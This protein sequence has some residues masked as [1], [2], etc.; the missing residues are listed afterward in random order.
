M[1]IQIAR[2][3]G[4]EVITT[5]SSRERAEFCKVLD[6]HNA[7]GAV[8]RLRSRFILRERA[9]A[10]ERERERACKP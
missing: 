5:S 6:V 10:R 7:N 9:R 8:L 2:Q 1:M 4:I 3:F